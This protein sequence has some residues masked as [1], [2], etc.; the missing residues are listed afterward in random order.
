MR[1][2]SGLVIAFLSST[3]AIGQTEVPNTFEAGQPARASEVNEN[4]SAMETA[5]NDNATALAANE[6]AIQQNITA[7][8]ALS[9]AEITVLDFTKPDACV[10]DQPGRYTLDR[11]WDFDFSDFCFAVSTEFEFI[12]ILIS[13]DDVIFDLNGFGLFDDPSGNLFLLNVTGARVTIRN[14]TIEG[15]DVFDR[16][17]LPLVVTG[18]DVLIENITATYIGA[19]G[20]H[21]L[22]RDCHVTKDGVG[23]GPGSTLENSHLDCG[24]NTCIIV[25]SD[26][27][28]RF[29]TISDSGATAGIEI[30]G[31][32]VLVESNV[33]TRGGGPS[34]VVIGN[35][36]TIVRNTLQ[37]N[38]AVTAE[39][40]VRVEGTGNIIDSNIVQPTHAVGILFLMDGNYYGDNRVSATTPFDLVGTTQTD[41]GGNVEF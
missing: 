32:N 29:N 34:I 38:N 37:T 23:L 18:P 20:S 31:D 8:S 22:V 9:S 15:G 1:A 36:N 26:A 33:L 16:Q 19:W 12:R 7:I 14:G 24:L 39:V 30:R 10:I 3:M 40:A 4:F 13:A 5:V 17:G 11:T 41:W 6:T 27:M 28:V 21:G 25:G 2:I 35:S